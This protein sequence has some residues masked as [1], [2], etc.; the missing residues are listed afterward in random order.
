MLKI[1]LKPIAI[2]AILFA[3]VPSMLILS[4]WPNHPRAAKGEGLNFARL[5]SPQAQSAIPPAPPQD[6][7]TAKDGSKQPLRWFPANAPDAPILILLH[8]SSWHGLQFETLGQKLAQAGIASVAAPDLRGHGFAPKRR[9]DLDYIGQFDDDI[10]ALIADLKARAPGAPILL[11]GHSSGGGLVVRYAGS[12]LPQPDGYVLLAPFLKHNA[13]TMRPNAGGWSNVLL[14][15]M[16]GLSIFNSLGITALNRLTVI[17][18]SVSPQVADGPLGHTLTAQYSYR[19][20]TAYA[21][22]SDY[23]ADIA[24]LKSPFA[25]IAGAKDEAFIAT[26]YEPLI[27]Q[28]SDQGQYNIVPEI[29]HLDIVDA[30][31]TSAILTEFLAGF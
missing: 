12:G 18:F 31:Q 6:S 10:A 24:G 1:F 4:Q 17:E 29:G 21:P 13:P 2:S 8:G 16:I 26:E 28:Y 11:G 7:Y 15:R 23:T 20:N 9:G 5:D 30:E 14:R 22:R 3:A 27:S 25:L 19:L